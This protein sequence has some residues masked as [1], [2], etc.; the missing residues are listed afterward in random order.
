MSGLSVA[1]SRK[2]FDALLNSSVDYCVDNRGDV[3]SWVRDASL[4]ALEKLS[5]L[6]IKYDLANPSSRK[7]ISRFI[8]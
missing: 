5:I 6:M 3:G 7:Y 2:I 8:Y 1:Q 4:Q